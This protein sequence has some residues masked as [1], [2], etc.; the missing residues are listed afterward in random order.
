MGGVVVQPHAL[1]STLYGEVLSVS[2]LD[3]PKAPSTH[4]KS[5]VTRGL[6]GR[7]G[8]KTGLY[9]VVICLTPNVEGKKLL[10]LGR[11]SGRI[12]AVWTQLPFMTCTPA[13]TAGCR[14][15]GVEHG[16]VYTT[17]VKGF[18]FFLH[19][20]MKCSPFEIAI[21]VRFR[22]DATKMQ[23]C[24]APLPTGRTVHFL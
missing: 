12:V 1:T 20:K 21:Y 24:V 17:P 14:N 7:V 6:R 8:P 18:P 23:A 16:N 4:K 15:T 11:P 9:T 19:C 22:S 10:I 13:P 5:S 3:T 2:R